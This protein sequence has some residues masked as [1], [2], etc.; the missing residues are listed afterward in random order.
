[1][2]DGTEYGVL[3]ALIGLNLSEYESHQLPPDVDN[4]SANLLIIKGSIKAVSIVKSFYI[5]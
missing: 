4:K 1:M 3:A 5:L 2:G